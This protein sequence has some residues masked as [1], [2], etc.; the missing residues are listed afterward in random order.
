MNVFGYPEFRT[1]PLQPDLLVVRRISH[2]DYLKLFFQF[3]ENRIQV[4]ICNL[5]MVPRLRTRITQTTCLVWEQFYVMLCNNCAIVNKKNSSFAL[6]CISLLWQMFHACNY[7]CC[8]VNN[9]TSRT[10]MSS[11]AIVIFMYQMSNLLLDMY[12]SWG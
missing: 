5:H 11:M 2:H 10:W 1:S 6:I 8:S 12:F 3:K 4:E 7:W 9:V